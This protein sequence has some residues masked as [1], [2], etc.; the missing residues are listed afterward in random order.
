MTSSDAPIPSAANA[1]SSMELDTLDVKPTVIGIYGL[2]GSGKTYLIDQ[3]KRQLSAEDFLFYDGSAVIAAVVPGGL[4]AFSRMADQGQAQAREFAIHHIGKECIETKKSAIVAG[5]FMFWPKTNDGVE[6]SRSP[7]PVWTPGDA[8]T[9]THILY[10]DCPVSLLMERRD[11]DADRERP[12][13]MKWQLGSW[14]HEEKTQLRKLC[15]DLGILFSLVHAKPPS[16]LLDR[17]IALVSD[18]VNHSEQENMLRAER[19]LDEVVVHM[20][21]KDADEPVPAMERMLVIDGDRTLTAQDTGSLLWNLARRELLVTF[22]LERD[23]LKAI[24]GSP[25]GYSYTAFRQATLV[26]EE[27]SGWA[28]FD[29]LVNQVAEATDLYDD[30]VSLLRIVATQRHM[31]AILVTCGLRQVWERIV[32]VAGLSDSVKVIGGGRL[33]D[34]FVVTAAVKTALVS[35]LQNVYSLETWAFGDSILDLGMLAAA[36]QAIVVVVMASGA[37]P[38]LSATTLPVTTLTDPDFMQA[39]LSR[40]ANG[41]CV[42]VYILEMTNEKAAKILM[43]PT[44]D[45][46]VAGPALRE[47]HRRAGWFLANS[48]VPTIVGVEEYQIPHVQGNSTAGHHLL[49]ESRTMVVALM[50]GGEPMALG[51]NDA[52]PLAA[53]LHANQPEDITKKHLE[54][55]RTIILVDSVVNSGKSVLEFIQRVWKLADSGRKDDGKEHGTIRIIVVAGVVQSQ[56]VDKIRSSWLSLKHVNR[57]TLSLIALRLSENKFTGKGGTDTGNRLFNTTSLD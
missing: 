4:E 53:L 40:R 9:Y 51:V 55:M 27:M 22:A 13:M 17:A 21:R 50:R 20:L 32:A 2:P 19:R 42:S 14:Q 48:F 43:T 57:L 34:E 29:G 47:T 49:D 10:L 1:D 16:T 56:A 35:R 18:F 7:P 26:Y 5:H 25:M 15:Y 39:I 6:G 23:P 33:T 36:N 8:V 24:F 30:F 45:A 52:F 31:G 37:P 3:L 41:T 54:I 12:Q 44:R 38:R 46:S 28:E 11:K